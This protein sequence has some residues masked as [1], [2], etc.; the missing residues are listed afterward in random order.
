MK[1]VVQNPCRNEAETLPQTL[2]EL[3]RTV[4]V[5]DT[6]EWLIIDLGTTDDTVEVAREHGGDHVGKHLRHLRRR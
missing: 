5:F 3:S 2:A 4:E 6:V 1:F